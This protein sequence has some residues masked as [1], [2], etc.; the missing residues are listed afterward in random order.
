MYL[1]MDVDFSLCFIELVL[2][3]RIALFIGKEEEEIDMVPHGG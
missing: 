2:I 1:K 3:E